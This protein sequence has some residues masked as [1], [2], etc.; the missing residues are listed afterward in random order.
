MI[1]YI[2]TPKWFYG[3]DIFFEMF[4]VIVVLLVAR[5][6][7]KLYAITQDKKHRH[8][9]LFFMMLGIALVFKILSNFTIYYSDV[10]SLNIANSV[11]YFET[12]HMSE[13]L[14]M[15]GYTVFRFLMMAAF[16]GLLYLNWKGNSEMFMLSTIFIFIV[17]V[18]SHS[19]YFI[20]HIVT[21]VIIIMLLK[22]QMR[23]RAKPSTREHGL[24][25][26][27]FLLLLISQAAF[28]LSAIDSVLYVI[29]E[30]FQ[31]FGF[32]VMLYGYMLV[33]KYEKKAR[34]H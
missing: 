11:F 12:S 33:M 8:F 2:F 13:I 31:T 32:S 6:G 30:F 9:S 4:S 22:N 28:T 23:I 26:M 16:F 3:I 1:Q 10:Y 21:S 27:A 14:F 24:A 29:G 25:S 20:F 17:S 34:P 5:Y 15:L 18:F 19:A 7:Y